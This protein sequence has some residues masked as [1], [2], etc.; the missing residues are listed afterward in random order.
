[1][2]KRKDGRYRQKVTLPS[3]EIKYVYGYS[4]KEV[5]DARDNLML[6]YALG[7]TNIN[8]KITVQEWAEKWW[9]TA[10]EGKTGASS[11]RTYV[12]T[13]NNYILPAMGSS[14]LTDI[15]PI[16]IQN[17]INSIGTSGKSKSLQ[18]KVLITLNAIFIYAMRNGLIV[19]NPA[20]FIDIID[21]PVNTREA[22]TVAQTNKLLEIC[23]GLRAELA[24]HLALFCGLRRGEIVALKWTDIDEINRALVITEAVE[25]KHNQ[26]K[27]K[28]TKSKAGNRVIPIPPHLWD[29]LKR[30]PKRS[31]FVVPSAR[32]V[33]LSETG[34]RRLMDPVERR[35]NK[36]E[37]GGFKATLHML[38]H[39]YATNLDK[40]GVSDKSCQYLLGHAEIRTTKNI[41]THFQDEHLDIAAQQ[42]E[43]LYAF[44]T[45]GVRKGS[46]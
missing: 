28:D 15:K 26:P 22:L 40:M 12:S 36:L 33:Q 21:V 44:S 35:L 6:Q 13:L 29:M 4:K 2:K 8:T 30:E 5:S 42:L 25:Y 18:R 24:I 46:N 16:H 34:V 23:Q 39:T 14:K 7:A 20:Q 11:Q 43:N 45:Q 41:Y 9:E 32:G 1:M 19:S 27:P 3:G 17:L 10:K 37:G 31:L 38:R